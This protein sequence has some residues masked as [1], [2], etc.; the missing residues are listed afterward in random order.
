MSIL[1]G[2]TLTRHD[3]VYGHSVDVEAKNEN[4]LRYGKKNVFEK[5]RCRGTPG[6]ERI[7]RAKFQRHRSTQKRLRTVPKAA[8]LRG[9]VRLLHVRFRTSSQNVHSLKTGC[10]SLFSGFRCLLL[11]PIRNSITTK[12]TTPLPNNKKKRSGACVL[13]SVFQLVRFFFAPEIR[14]EVTKFNYYNKK[15]LRTVRCAPV[16]LFDV[17]QTRAIA[18]SCSRAGPH[19]VV[20]LLPAPHLAPR[21]RFRTR[22]IVAPPNAP[23]ETRIL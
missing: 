14:V 1:T 2:H 8:S 9:H 7:L 5:F 15:T 22:K 11:S 13:I 6:R 16:F 21:H 12:V 19:A 23:W 20:K 4:S 10:F 17:R 3:R 18:S